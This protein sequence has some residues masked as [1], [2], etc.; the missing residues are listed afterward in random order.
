MNEEIV[1]VQSTLH[2]IQGTLEILDGEIEGL[3]EDFEKTQPIQQYEDV[4]ESLN[5]R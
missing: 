2:D 4:N 1:R 5:L 3:H